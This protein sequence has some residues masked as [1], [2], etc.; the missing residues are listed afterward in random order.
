MS[1][2]DFAATSLLMV[3]LAWAVASD[4][5]TFRIPNRIPMMV[6]G[7]FAAHA[8][9]AWPAIDLAGAF[10]VGAGCLAAGFA[11]YAF[12]WFGAGDAKLFAAL[13]LW[14]GPALIADLILITS[15]AGAIMALLV[16]THH[17]ARSQLAMIAG[18]WVAPCSTP[19]RD[20]RL[21]YGIAI[22]AGGVYLATRLI[23]G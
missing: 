18:A 9:A 22:A 1:P 19:L 20:R 16:M 4:A 21:P 2:I 5:G 15:M 10:A 11:V 8:L 17:M 12:G 6:A 3:P 23:G 13:G 14:A 7:L